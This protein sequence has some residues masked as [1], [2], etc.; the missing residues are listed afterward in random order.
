MQVPESPDLLRKLT[1]PTLCFTRV[2]APQR[3]VALF[4]ACGGT[5][6][7]HQDR[8][9]LS[10][11]EEIFHRFCARL[12][13][14]ASHALRQAIRS[15]LQPIP[16]ERV[17]RCR[18]R[19]WSLERT[20]IM[21]VVNVTPDSFSDGGRY[22]EHSRALE[23]AL[24]LMED[25]ADILDIGGES[26]RPGAA[27]VPLA[28][29]LRRV[30]P[31]VEALASQTSVLIS[32]DTTK[33]RVAREALAAGAHIINDITAFSD[34]EMAPTVAEF[35][36]GVV[37]MHMQG[38]PQ[39]MQ[40]NPH[41][42][43]VV[44]EIFDYLQERVRFAEGQGIPQDAIA[45]DPGIGFGKTLEHN[46]AILRRL[47]EFRSLGCPLVIGTSRKSFI[48]TL[49]DRPVNERLHGTSATVACAILRGANIVRV[50]DVR[51]MKQVAVVTDALR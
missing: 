31:L 2:S 20:G 34:P 6:L 1:Y 47:D 35:Q 8:L 3:F 16:R 9:V 24:Q 28:E 46:L 50:H 7:A 10:G 30:I 51:E 48:G 49:L 27:P 19:T 23:H 26:S 45:V 13:S 25:G 15:L 5:A 44:G 18:D 21:G 43:D 36:A 14:P 39:T 22:F 37:L 29:E 12:E 11:S 41:Y 38:T 42:E 33:A 40:H 4:E 17:W 32:V